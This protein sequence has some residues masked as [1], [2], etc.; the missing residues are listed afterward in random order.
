[1][2]ASQN[3]TA[4]E[5]PKTHLI[6]E[7]LLLYEMISHSSFNIKKKFWKEL[8]MLLSTRQGSQEL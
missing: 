1:M 2:T 7:S 8:T 6:I 3:I 4:S 5:V